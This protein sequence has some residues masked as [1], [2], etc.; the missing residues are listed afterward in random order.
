MAPGFLER[1]IR[2]H[3][4]PTVH[5]YDPF[6]PS[7]RARHQG[8]RTGRR[9]PARPAGGCRRGVPP[10]GHAPQPLALHAG[11]LAPGLPDRPVPLDEMTV[12]LLQPSV[13]TAARKKVWAEL[14][15]RTRSGSP[16]VQPVAAAGLLAGHPCPRYALMTSTAIG[17]APVAP[18]PPPCTTTPTAM[19]AAA[20]AKA[21]KIASS[22][23]LMAF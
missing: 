19:E 22:C 13:S 11:R 23:P 14:V 1:K 4:K 17:P 12:L 6:P 16:P 7:Q 2:D 3:E 8:T 18:K 21:A 10:A 5:P 9:L 15:R 20:G